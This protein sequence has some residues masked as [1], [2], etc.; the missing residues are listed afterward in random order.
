MK[1]AIYILRQ[2][3]G[4]P[5]PLNSKERVCGGSGAVVPWVL[6]A[7]CRH[8]LRKLIDGHS[9][10][11]EPTCLSFPMGQGKVTHRLLPFPKAAQA[12]ISVL[13][14]PLKEQMKSPRPRG[15]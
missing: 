6:E 10:Q 13:T 15:K 1:L 5:P 3:S 9:A 11:T 4:Q 14:P 12:V 7:Q 2:D 8:H